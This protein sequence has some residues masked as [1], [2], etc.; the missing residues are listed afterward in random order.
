VFLP[1]SCRVPAGRDAMRATV[2]GDLDEALRIHGGRKP[3]PML[4]VG[5]WRETGCQG[6]IELREHNRHLLVGLHDE[7]ERSPDDV[8]SEQADGTDPTVIA[9]P[10]TPATF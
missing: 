1:G 7:P 10:G 4:A 3:G 6:S 9:D 5:Y 8:W 2:G